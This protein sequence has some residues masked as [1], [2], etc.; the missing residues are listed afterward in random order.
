MSK[1]SKRTK[2]VAGKKPKGED[3]A[4]HSNFPFYKLMTIL[5]E[6]MRFEAFNRLMAWK[7]GKLPHG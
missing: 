4:V 6:K 3:T 2:Y 5:N 7:I 1:R